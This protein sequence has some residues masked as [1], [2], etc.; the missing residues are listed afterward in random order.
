MLDY[1]IRG[2]LMKKFISFGLVATILLAV[3]CV[4]GV[5]CA[6]KNTA[7]SSY[8]I[9]C[10][11]A[12]NT[13][14]G[15]EKVIFYNSTENTFSVL[16]FNLFGNAFRKDAKYSPINRSHYS[17]SYPQGV[18]YG[19][20]DVVNVTG[21]GEKVPTELEYSICGVDQNILEVKLDKEVFPNE[22]Y[23]VNIE[24]ILNLASVV[25]R[26]GANANTV[27]LANFYPILCGIQD[28][29]FYECTY[30]SFGDPF[31]SDCA[32][33][34]VTLTAEEKYTVAT[35]GKVV[36]S[37][38][39]NGKTTSAYKLD[40]ARSF[41]MVLSS[42]FDV[43]TDSSTGTEINY[44]FYA[45]KTP[46]QSLKTAILS[47]KCFNDTFGEYP[48]PTFSVVETEFVQGGMEFPALVMISS[49]LEEKAYMEVIVHETAHQWW[50]T[51]VGNN[52]VECGFL[53]E[54]LAEYSVV[55]FYE[56]NAEYGFTRQDLINSAEKTYKTF[57]SVYDKIFGDVDTTMIRSLK[58]FSS[59]YE[60]VNIAYVKPC[61]MY[62]CL[63]QTLGEEK[64]FKGLK[65]YY[66]AYK[67]KNADPYSIVGTYE[68]LGA[69]V[70]GFFESFYNGKAVL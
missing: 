7:R 41:A 2:I 36:E 26:T 29:G 34:I 61:V 24:F 1:I 63:R 52:E 28:G 18:S 19:G 12:E 15:S 4:M 21:K 64:F 55:V 46:E 60:Y 57:C 58:D 6:D 66:K 39:A 50:Q 48:Y 69:D 59:E 17:Q 56:R 10:E 40:N 30:Y 33:Y 22:T 49:G 68:K 44:Y 23:E 65:E 25:A 5:G 32:D 38:N 8:E 47:V 9:S 14:T 13:L 43:L 51:V 37:V 54:G 70:D 35:S 20:M 11:F 16:K 42:K 62:D 3:S 27:N 45:D 31:F 53:D 67:F